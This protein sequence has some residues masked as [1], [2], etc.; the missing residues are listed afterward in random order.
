MKNRTPLCDHVREITSAAATRIQEIRSGKLD[1]F[2]KQDDSPVTRADREAD[3]LLKTELTKL[4]P[5]AWLSEETADSPDRLDAESIW[6]VDPLDGTKEFIKGLPEYCVAVALVERGQPMLGV[7]HN[8]ATGDVFWAIRGEGAY[9][10]GDRISVREGNRILASRSEVPRGEFEPFED[11]WEIEPTGSIQHKL[12]L[13]AAGQGAVTLSRG[14]KH[15]WDVCAGDRRGGR[16][17]RDRIAR[18]PTRLQ[19]AVSQ[20]QRD[21]GR[22]ARGLP[23]CTFATARVRWIRPNG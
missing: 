9:L 23:P 8:P 6:I 20:S 7:A 2:S 12:A 10:N 22:C 13:V 5:A 19:S 18:R 11:R 4:Y 14:P 21:P 16:R 15:E 17:P 3:A 1:T